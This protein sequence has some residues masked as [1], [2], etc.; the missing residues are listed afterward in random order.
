MAKFLSTDWKVSVNGVILS[1][2][3][4]DVQIADEKDR[5]EVSGFSPTGAREFLPGLAEQTVTIQFLADFKAA[6]AGAVHATI[7][8]LYTAGSAFPFFVQPDSDTATSATNPLY[9][10]TAQVFSYPIGAT[11]NERTEQTVE[12][13]PAPNSSFAWG[14]TAP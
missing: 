9:G 12:F 4:F 8:P 5:V 2:H 11:L 3:A 13:A 6:A 14:T 7:Y 1:D 10:G